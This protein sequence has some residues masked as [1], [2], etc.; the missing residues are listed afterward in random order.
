[1]SYLVHTLAVADVDDLVA[2]HELAS[3][4][5]RTPD[6][7]AENRALAALA[8]EL[9]RH[10]EGVAGRVEDVLRALCRCS[11]A[12]AS[13]PAPDAGFDW[14]AVGGDGILLLRDPA[15]VFPSLCADGP[16]PAEMLLATWDADG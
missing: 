6:H 8:L 5:A 12:G 7:A 1:M 13:L 11:A 2:T 14:R 16:P 4:P 3:R 9:A 15:R 10:P